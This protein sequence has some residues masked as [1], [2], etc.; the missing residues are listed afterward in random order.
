MS[1]KLIMKNRL[2]LNHI[3]VKIFQ[4][5]KTCPNVK[6]KIYKQD[7]A[8]TTTVSLFWSPSAIEVGQYWI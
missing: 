7:A 8:A 5:N 1:D 6:L 3:R 4:S 2:S